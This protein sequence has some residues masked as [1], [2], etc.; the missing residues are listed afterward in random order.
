[1]R[2][3]PRIASRPGV[4]PECNIKCLIF[5]STAD[6]PKG[7]RLPWLARLVR[8]SPS[9]G[10]THWKSSWHHTDVFTRSATLETSS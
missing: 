1:M 2:R 6:P 10:H 5:V 3:H 8:G 7:T 9:E 4:L